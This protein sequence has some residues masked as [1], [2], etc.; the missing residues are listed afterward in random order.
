[1]E[2]GAGQEGDTLPLSDAEGDEEA[3]PQGNGV[4][5]LSAAAAAAFADTPPEEKDEDEDRMELETSQAAAGGGGGGDGPSNEDAMDDSAGS[6]RDAA[7]A[8]AMGAAAA[9]SA[10]EDEALLKS[11]ATWRCSRLLS[12][13]LPLGATLEALHT[14]VRT[15]PGGGGGGGGGGGNGG[16]PVEQGMNRSEVRDV[17]QNLIAH[18]NELEDSAGNADQIIRKLENNWF[19]PDAQHFIAEWEQRRRHWR[20]ASERINDLIRDLRHQLQEQTRTSRA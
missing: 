8:A 1:M 18:R 17:L 19:G 20:T 6:G 10:E 13:G 12:A 7:A 9:K 2:E 14:K 3:E 15:Y 11:L 16:G 5:A 4:E